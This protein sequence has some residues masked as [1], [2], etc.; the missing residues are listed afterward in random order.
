MQRAESAGICLHALTKITLVSH[1]DKPA[2]FTERLFTILDCAEVCRVA[3]LARVNLAS[4][5]GP[6]H[7]ENL[8]SSGEYCGKAEQRV[9]LTR[10]STKNVARDGC[11][12]RRY[13]STCEGV[14]LESY[15]EMLTCIQF[16]IVEFFS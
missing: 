11:A 2:N 12:T 10:P 15:I 13:P 7:L 8:T 6:Q 5:F 16:L 4:R 3:S 1:D 9:K 14:F